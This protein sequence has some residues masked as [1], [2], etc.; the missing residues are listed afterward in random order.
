MATAL[1]LRT[2]RHHRI[3]RQAVEP[4][5]R[6]NPH[7]ALEEA[8]RKL[9]IS[10]PIWLDKNEREWEEFGQTR[11]LPD[12]FLDSVDFDRMEIEYIDPDAK[13]E[14]VK[15]PAQCFLTIGN[16]QCAMSNSAPKAS[17]G[18]PQTSFVFFA[19]WK[20]FTPPARKISR[21]LELNKSTI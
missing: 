21:L 18:R 8:C 4:C 11:F 20:L 2:I 14:K 5:T 19:R 13:K 17:G 12:A 10:H 1:W 6:D 16:Q 7:D 15:R 3:D 9:D